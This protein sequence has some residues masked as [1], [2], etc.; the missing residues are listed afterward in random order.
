MYPTFPKMMYWDIHICSLGYGYGYGNHTLHLNYGIGMLDE[1][2]E[3]MI[4]QALEVIRGQ[5][6][7][8]C[9]IYG[10]YVKDHQWVGKQ[11]G[12]WG[13]YYP[14]HYHDSPYYLGCGCQFPWMV[15]YR[16]GG[17]QGSYWHGMNHQGRNPRL[18]RLWAPRD[19]DDDEVDGMKN[20]G[21]YP[22]VEGLADLGM[23]GIVDR[24]RAPRI[25]MGE[26][27]CN[28]WGRNGDFEE[29]GNLVVEGRD[30]E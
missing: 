30:R 6:W 21:N 28:Q 15:C 14:W 24:E 3:L 25:V 16:G 12:K 19:D 13:Y 17:G 20:I 2:L 23:F 18:K 7:H 22:G 4:L 29:E 1:N 27:S 10:H 8:C 11:E 9:W 26:D 5:M